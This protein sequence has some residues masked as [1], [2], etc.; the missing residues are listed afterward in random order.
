M[1]S[2]SELIPPAQLDETVRQLKAQIRAIQLRALSAHDDVRTAIFRETCA[3][4]RLPQGDEGDDGF[5]GATLPSPSTRAQPVDYV[6]P[7]S[8]GGK[9]IHSPRWKGVSP[10]VIPAGGSSRSGG[11]DLSVISQLEA[12]IRELDLRIAAATPTAEMCRRKINELLERAKLEKDATQ[13]ER[14]RIIA[15]TE[16]LTSLKFGRG[17]ETDD[18]PPRARSCSGDTDEKAG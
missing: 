2:S 8:P 16:R 5:V 12:E 6:E 13:A 9:L 4:Q 15:A 14:C 1:A 7:S 17:R 18:T 11:S 3:N 10:A